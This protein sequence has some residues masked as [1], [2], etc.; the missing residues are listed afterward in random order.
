MLLVVSADLGFVFLM[1]QLAAKLLVVLLTVPAILL[2]RLIRHLH[3]HCSG[4]HLRHMCGIHRHLLRIVVHLHLIGIEPA[5]HHRLLIVGH[6]GILVY[7]GTRSD[8]LLRGI[9]VLNLSLRILEL[10]RLFLLQ[11]VNQKYEI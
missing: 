4:V 11:R 7:V 8:L 3:P 1:V 5:H 2:V 6:V 9:P 10:G